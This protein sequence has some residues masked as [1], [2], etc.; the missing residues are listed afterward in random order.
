VTVEFTPPG[1]TQIVLACL[2]ESIRLEFTVG[3]GFRVTFGFTP[4]DTSN[5]LV[6]DD[7]TLGQLD[8]NVLGF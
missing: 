1:V 7:A 8:S 4:R 2:I 5:Y 3:Q 6:L